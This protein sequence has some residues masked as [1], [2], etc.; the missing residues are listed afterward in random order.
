MGVCDMKVDERDIWEMERDGK[1]E[2]GEMR[3]PGGKSRQRI[4]AYSYEDVT[5]LR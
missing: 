2:G 1:R 5:G 3:K 4:M